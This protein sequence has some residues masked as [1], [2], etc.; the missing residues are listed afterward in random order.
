M[1]EFK[2]R[3][4]N[5][6][7]GMPLLGFLFKNQIFLFVLK[8]AV[9]LL[10]FYGIYYG[11]VHQSG[12]NIFTRYLFW[13]LF[14]SFFMV[15]SLSTMGRIFCGICPHGF[16]GKYITRWG[17]QKPMPRFLQNRFIGLML[18]FFGWWGVYYAAPGLFKTPLATALLFGG[19]TLLAFIVYFLYKDMAYCKYICPIGSLTRGYHKVSSTWLGTYNEDCGECKTFDCAKACSYNLKPFTFDKKNSMEDCTLCMDCSA[20]CESVSY[21]FKKPSFSLFGKFK[22]NKAEVWTFILITAAITITMNFHHALGRSAIVDAL[23]WSVSAQWASQFVDFGS[24]DAVGIFAFTYATLSTLALVFAGM[25]LASKLLKADFSKTFYT[26]GYAFSPIFI[27]GGLSHTVEFF[28]LHTYANI[29]NGFIQGFGIDAE[30]VGNLATRK[31]AWVHSFTFFNYLAGIWAFAIMAK[32]INFFEASRLRKAG[33][34]VFASS[35]II[36]YLWLNVYKV[37]VFQTYGMNRSGHSHHGGGGK[38]F[39]SVDKERAVIV[40]QG[41]DKFSGVVCGMNLPKFYKTNHSAELDGKARQ[42]CSLHCV[43][44]DLHIKRLPL[45]KIKVVDA[46]TLRFID[47]KQAFYVVGS[48]KAGTMTPTSKYAFAS[49]KDAEAFRAD[50]GGEIMDFDRAVEIALKDFKV[51]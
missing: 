6:I 24:L 19:M 22:Y 38:M 9:A 45:Q 17:L 32:R 43:A 29:A 33:A 44:E 41:A 26:L 48:K 5:D 23:P 3:D 34:F 37:Y 15:L 25:F 12:D 50:N 51:E 11:F 18:I 30:K 49:R 7:Y 4:R 10:F 13:G 16:L 47:A 20:A 39:Q 35:L 1:T 36:F 42:Y 27:I 8:A 28:F 46:K 2:K 14:W 21:K 40:Q 31:D